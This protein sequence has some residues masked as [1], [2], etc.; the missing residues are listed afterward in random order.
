[1]ASTWPA[2]VAADPA[3][4]ERGKDG[5]VVSVAGVFNYMAGSV[6]RTLRANG[7]IYTRRDAGG[8]DGE[9]VGA[10]WSPTEVRVQN[11]RP[12][13]AQFSMDLQGV[14][15]HR[16]PTGLRHDDF[17]DED[18]VLTRYYPECAELVKRAT[19]AAVVHVFDHNI[20]SATGK[21]AGAAAGAQLAVQGPATLVHADY[22]IA[23]GPA[24][25]EQLARP[26]KENDALRKVLG[27]APLLPAEALAMAKRGRFAIVNVWRSILDDPVEVFPLAWI[28]A[29][30]CT[31]A[32]DLCVFEIHYAD[33]VGENY[34]VAHAPRHR[35]VY[36]PKMARDEAMLIKQW[37]SQGT[38][39]GGHRASF[40]IHSAF[41]D[42]TSPEGAQDRES[43]E[44]RCICVFD[45]GSSAAS[46]K[47]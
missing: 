11:G 5:E 36:F 19:G 37:D 6:D 10:P 15:L 39:L 47:L 25:L 38:L 28:D 31:A 1:M 18:A 34:F 7:K 46:S 44:T 2:A 45:E 43:I 35:W 20:R 21:K 30:S 33:R 29:R 23:S 3:K 22:T 14:E 17:Y 24:R 8:S 27:A 9:L 32:E 12:E 26:P 13:A 4:V 16:S 41:L 40:A 42:P